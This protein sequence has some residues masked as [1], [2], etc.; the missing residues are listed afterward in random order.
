MKHVA[1]AHF[2][3][4]PVDPILSSACSPG[5]GIPIHSGTREA[6][7]L[8][9]GGWRYAGPGGPVRLRKDR[10][11]A[12]IP[13]AEGLDAMKRPLILVVDDTARDLELLIKLLERQ[14]YAVRGAEAGV[15][16]L[17]LVGRE[18]P[19]LILLDVL[20]P[21]LDGIEVCRRLKSDPATAGI[22]VIFLTGQSES[23][24]ILAGFE[25]GAVDYVTKPFRVPELLARV[26]VHMDLR[27]AQLEISTLR[28]ILPTCAH[29]KRIRDE[30]GT[31]HRIETFI[32]QHSEAQFSHGCCPQ[33]IP[34]C[35]P[36]Y[37]AGLPSGDFEDIEGPTEGKGLPS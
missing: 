29:C 13:N 34:V 20:M 31:W 36:D 18:C 24:E 1:G 7:E 12:P 10:V 16:A 11:D 25:A 26:R 2:P 21:G 5:W 23:G 19:D 14:G 30:K 6:D 32:S 15:P 17:A 27:R 3:W 4:R 22:P 9:P 35:F 28:G 33:C 8:H 37:H